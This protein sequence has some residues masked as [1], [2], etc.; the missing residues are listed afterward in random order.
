MLCSISSP[1]QRFQYLSVE[2]GNQEFS[3]DGG[4]GDGDDGDDDDVTIHVNVST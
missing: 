4:G 2:N 3:I 1:V